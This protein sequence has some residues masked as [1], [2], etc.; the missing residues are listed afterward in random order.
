VGKAKESIRE[1]HF[2]KVVLS[3]RLRISTEA[4]PAA[5]F[6]SLLQAYPD[7]FCYWWYHPATGSWLGASPELLLRVSEDWF[8]T[9]ALAG[10]LKYN[11]PDAPAWGV[12]EY[13]EQAFVADYI[14]EILKSRASGLLFSEPVSVRAGGL[15]HLRTAIGGNM[16]ELKAGELIGALH[17]T[18]AV[19]GLPLKASLAF[20]REHEGYD[21]SFYTGYLGGWS[22]GA[23]GESGTGRAFYV[24]LRCMQ[25]QGRVATVYVGAGI[26]A[27]SEAG[28]EWQETCDKAGTMFRV[29]FNSV[30]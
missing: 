17:P 6:L 21:R 7:A 28:R 10:T 1:G 23:A 14:G 16:G 15:W 29:L 2:E 5:V 9:S 24:N 19:C 26:T 30:Q 11:G 3:R 22:E 4:Q 20:I 18:P 25:L 13:R 27:E 8:T 12:K